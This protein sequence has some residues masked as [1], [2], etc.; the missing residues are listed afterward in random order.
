MKLLVAIDGVLDN[1]FL[2]VYRCISVDDCAQTE[3][4]VSG[5][6]ADSGSGRNCERSAGTEPAARYEVLYISTSTSASATTSP[7]V[8]GQDSVSQRHQRVLCSHHTWTTHHHVTPTTTSLFFP[9]ARPT[10]GFY[11]KLCRPVPPVSRLFVSV[12]EGTCAK[13]VIT[14]RSLRLASGQSK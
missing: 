1:L 5:F 7:F 2:K 14:A 9:P 10:S 4:L 11:V 6:G 8:L 3:I 12:C 13:E